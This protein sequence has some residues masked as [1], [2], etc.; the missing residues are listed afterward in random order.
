M[1]TFAAVVDV[2]EPTFQNAQEF[3]T[4]W[5]SVNRDAEEL[6]GGVIDAFALLGHHDF[7]VLYEAPDVESALQISL[8]LERYGFDME[9][10]VAVPIDRLG[11][12]VEEL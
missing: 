8:S 6:G 2:D 7:L 11:D 4:I 9:T 5:G 3:A 12:L 1:P 10:M